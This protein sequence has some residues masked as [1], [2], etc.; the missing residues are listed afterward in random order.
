MVLN[1]GKGVAVVMQLSAEQWK[2]VLSTVDNQQDAMDSS[3]L[4]AR[5]DLKNVSYVL[6]LEG[7]PEP[8]PTFTFFERLLDDVVQT[9]QPSP[10]ITHVELCMSPNAAR[11]DMHFATYFGSRASW[12]RDV[13]GQR[14]FYLGDNAS[15]WRAVPIVCNDASHRLRSECE[16]HVSTPYSLAKYI[17]ALPPVRALA[18]FI[19]DGAKQ[20]AHCAILTARCLRAALPDLHIC[21]PSH[22]F[23]PS[24]LFLELDAEANRS[25]FRQRLADT[26]PQ[27]R[28]IVEDE[29]E[30][31]AMH[32]LLHDSDVLIQALSEESCILALHRLTMRSLE[33]GLD[34]VAKRI[35]QKQLATALLRYSVARNSSHVRCGRR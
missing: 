29:D 26:D 9:M 25:I 20:P 24:T 23:G 4:E 16:N 5:S 28:A 21:H 8:N 3:P 34:D 11:E 13:G 14:E 32:T 30:T 1:S 31:R 18:G 22:W 35:C 33:Q 27:V 10:A 15:K 2:R 17:C 12:G 19:P 6:A 7:S